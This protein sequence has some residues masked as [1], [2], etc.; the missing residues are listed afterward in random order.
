M[1]GFPTDKVR[2][3]AGL[4]AARAAF[5]RARHLWETQ[6]GVSPVNEAN[7]ASAASGWPNASGWEEPTASHPLAFF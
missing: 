6:I 2:E 3:I 7:R 4:H 5:E 1:R